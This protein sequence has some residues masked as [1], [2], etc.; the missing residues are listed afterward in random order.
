MYANGRG[1]F[2]LMIR[3]TGGAVGSTLDQSTPLHRDYLRGFE[4]IVH[5]PLQ[6]RTS[7]PR[8]ILYNM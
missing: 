8:Y 1:A 5:D 3:Y 4:I 2:L 7:P 6:I